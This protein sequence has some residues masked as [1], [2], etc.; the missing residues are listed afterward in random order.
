MVTAQPTVERMLLGGMLKR[1]RERSGLSQVEA[2]Q[3]VGQDDTRIGR[4]ESGVATLAADALDKLLAFYRVDANERETALVFGFEARK[5][6]ARRTHVYV[7][8]LPGAFQ[9]FADLEA[10]AHTILWYESSVIPGLLQSP[11]YVRAI[12]AVGENTWW[13]PSPAILE[14]RAEFRLQR[15][16]NT[17]ESD[18]SKELHFIIGE[19]ALHEIVGSAD[20]MVE[21][22]R[23]LQKIMDERRDTTIQLVPFTTPGNPARGGGFT[24]LDFGS[25]ALT[26]GFTPVMNG[27]SAFY[28]SDENVTPMIR[29]FR[30]I[31]QLA[32]SHEETRLAISRKLEE[33]AS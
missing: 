6:V 31:S 10:S 17:W 32:L 13:K 22:L 26:V 28:D 18:I 3:H 30:H 33:I 1:F 8:T 11:A 27:P 4:V 2:G 7:D 5:R 20:V 29:T 16:K 9:R 12:I 24:V 14:N 21:Q 15:Q 23:H 25:N 19:A